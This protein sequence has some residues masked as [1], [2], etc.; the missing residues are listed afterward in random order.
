MNH[1][2]WFGFQ[3][4]VLNLVKALVLSLVLLFPS[5]VSAVEVL[6]PANIE[7]LSADLNRIVYNIPSARRSS[8]FRVKVPFN[9]GN[10][11]FLFTA[12]AKSPGARVSITRVAAP[13]GKLTYKF[14]PRRGL[15]FFR[16]LGLSFPL[17]DTAEVSM[18]FPMNA[19]VPVEFGTYTID[20]EIAGGYGLKQVAVIVKGQMGFRQAVDFN[21][22]VAINDPK[23]KSANFQTEFGNLIRKQ[24]NAMLTPHK[25]R[26]GQLRF[27]NSTPKETEGLSRPHVDEVRAMCNLMK[28]RVPRNRAVNLIWVDEIFYRPNFTFGGIAAGQPGS[29]FVSESSATCV[30]AAY[31]IYGSNLN[32]HAINFL[33]EG[34]HLMGLPH[35]SELDGRSFDKFDDTPECNLGK[36]D[37][38]SN[39]RFGYKGQRNGEVDDYECGIAGGANNFL[40]YG[41]LSDFEPFFISSEQAWVLKRHPLFYPVN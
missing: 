27:Y 28:R 11:S 31:N 6:Q 38:R 19:K 20:L 17:S 35:T 1:K 25:L 33:H 34:S 22:W 14:D 29:L 13:S 12:V 30:L 15:R 10:S 36:F 5:A 24:M 16:A 21:I 2:R 40:F 37:G 18:L 4:K 23:L 41:G 9:P 26:V 39:P 3:F 8:T 7:R 32:Q